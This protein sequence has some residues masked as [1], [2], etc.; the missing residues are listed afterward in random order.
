[1]KIQ[2]QQSSN[3]FRYQYI[4]HSRVHYRAI[5]YS[6]AA[7]QDWF[8]QITIFL[9]RNSSLFLQLKQCII[10]HSSYVTR[11]NENKGRTTNKIDKS[12]QL[13][14]GREARGPLKEPSM[15]E[16]RKRKEKT[17]LTTQRGRNHDGRRC[18]TEKLK[19][20]YFEKLF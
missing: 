2:N 13:N 9:F 14:W 8:N 10:K 1:M 18:L 6:A 19:S 12:P 7:K 20:D 5:H 16:E 4:T 15:R 17:N 11:E 3:N